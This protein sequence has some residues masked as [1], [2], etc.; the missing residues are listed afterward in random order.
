MISL[1]LLAL[2]PFLTGLALTASYTTQLVTEVLR[3]T[4]GTVLEATVTGHTASRE[5]TYAML[6]PVV[7]WTAPDGTA[8]ERALPDDIPARA[9]PE[10]TRVRIRFDPAHPE[11][12]ALDTDA[13]HRQC[14]TGMA[15]GTALWA[16][17]LIV[18]V[19][20]LAYLITQL[21][22]LRRY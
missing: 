22:A 16:G 18:V 20:R 17:T 19:W 10:G 3:R 1:W 6:H 2:I 7:A 12:A 4:T 5:A 8:H 14:V 15:L 21:T 9:L 11:L 13:R